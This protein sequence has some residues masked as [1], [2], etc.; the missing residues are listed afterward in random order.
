MF[1]SPAVVTDDAID[2]LGHASNVAYIRWVQDVAKAHSEH[3]GWTHDAYR[4]AGVVFVVRRHE[5]D[6]LRP[7]FAGDTLSMVTWIATWSAATSVRRTEL[8]RGD[9]VVARAETTWALVSTETGRPCRIPVAL[10]QAF[11]R[12]SA[13]S[14]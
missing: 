10:K 7:V 9:E 2:E 8:V 13:R 6:Y 11:S 1:Q 4:Q 12:A 3:V 5:I 14:S